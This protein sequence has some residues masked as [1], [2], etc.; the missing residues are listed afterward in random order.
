[1]ETRSAPDA[2]ASASYRERFKGGSGVP[3]RPAPRSPCAATWWPGG[4]K[5]RGARQL[6]AAAPG[7]P[8]GRGRR[9]EARQPA[10]RGGPLPA[11][12]AEWAR[13][14]FKG[15]KE[16]ARQHNLGVA[17]EALAYGFRPTRR[18][19][20]ELEQAREFYR[21]PGP[22]P[23]REVL[24]GPARAHRAQPGLR[25]TASQ[26]LAELEQFGQSRAAHRETP[27]PPAPAAPVVRPA[28]AAPPDAVAR[29]A[30]P[31]KPAGAPARPAPP[32]AAT[33]PAAPAKVLEAPPQAPLR[34][35]SFEASLAP[36]TVTAAGPS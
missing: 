19:P 1:M 8:P 5:R 27:P 33:T 31:P 10:G 12:L 36:W 35:G 34:N 14:T 3:P 16:A 29:P 25:R 22:G 30:A 7:G 9:A 26:Q 20:G 11:A 23:G 4:R 32:K 17:H 28:A 15:D 24:H 13:R 2:D 18:A 6:C 21:Q